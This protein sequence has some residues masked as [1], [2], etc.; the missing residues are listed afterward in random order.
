[1]FVMKN[2]EG[3]LQRKVYNLQKK[4]E[5]ESKGYV[6]VSASDDI[7]ETEVEVE[8]KELQDMKVSELKEYAKAHEIELD[9]ASNKE[10]IIK[11][12]Q[13]QSAKAVE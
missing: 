10:D 7:L 2:K 3:N 8:K 13:E 1:M 5:L 9:G 12:I 4:E 11:A 6:V